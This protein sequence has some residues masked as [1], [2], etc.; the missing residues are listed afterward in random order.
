MRLVF[1]QCT[2]RRP[3]EVKDVIMG[4]VPGP[5]VDWVT[6]PLQ[7]SGNS[8]ATATTWCFRRCTVR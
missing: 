2:P 6:D 3:T 5:D 4:E 7:E 1:R 8:F